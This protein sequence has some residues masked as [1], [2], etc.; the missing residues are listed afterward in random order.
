MR[1]IKPEEEII[2]GGDLHGHEWR[3]AS[4]KNT[5]ANVSETEMKNGKMSLDSLTH[6]TCD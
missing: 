1:N 5:E 4:N 6:I 2:I 3:V